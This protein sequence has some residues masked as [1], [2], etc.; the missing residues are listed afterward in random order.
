[1]QTVAH[2]LRDCRLGHITGSRSGCSAPFWWPP[3]PPRWRWRSSDQATSRP[4]RVSRQL[5]RRCRTPRH[6]AGLSR[7][8]PG[9]NPACGEGRSMRGSPSRQLQ[10]SV[11]MPTMKTHSEALQEDRQGQAARGVVVGMERS[12]GREYRDLADDLVF[13]FRENAIHV[14]V[15]ERFVPFI[16]GL[17]QRRRGPARRREP[18]IVF[19]G[20]EYS[21][22]QGSAVSDGCSADTDR[23]VVAPI[24][25]ASG[26]R[27]RR[28]A[29]TPQAG[30]PA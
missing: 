19:E 23:V 28:P 30:T 7:N 17:L 4:T 1:M 26:M 2:R 14:L 11:R 9:R 29:L 12:R 22:G 27:I 6:S 15:G 13:G 21:S 24:P 8:R 3:S 25:P 10:H 16:V 18:R 5:S 20:L